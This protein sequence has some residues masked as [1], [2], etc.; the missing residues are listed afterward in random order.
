MKITKTLILKYAKKIGKNNFVSAWYYHN[1][2]NK[3]KLAIKAICVDV[4]NLQD[5][6][7]QYNILE[8]CFIMD[9][10]LRILAN[11]CIDKAYMEL[12]K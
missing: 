7:K 8:N 5:K 2:D 9:E 6:L 4:Q 12:C 3:Y 1:K 11:N 10:S